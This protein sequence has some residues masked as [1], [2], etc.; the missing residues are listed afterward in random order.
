MLPAPT[1]LLVGVYDHPKITSDE[2][3]WGGR[4]TG[5]MAHVITF[6]RHPG[7]QEWTL[8]NF[9]FSHLAGVFFKTFKLVTYII[10][11]KQEANTFSLFTI[12]LIV[13]RCLVLISV[14]AVNGKLRYVDFNCKILSKLQYQ[15][16]PGFPRTS[17][18]HRLLKQQTRSYSKGYLHVHIHLQ[19]AGLVHRFAL[20]LTSG[21]R[22]CWMLL[23][24]FPDTFTGSH[25]LS[26]RLNAR[27]LLIGFCSSNH[28]SMNWGTNSGK[29]TALDGCHD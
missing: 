16:S 21:P 8:Q 14:A 2:K 23:T 12:G 19:T 7:W 1:I 26:S 24:T 3:V 28:K 9:L 20:A 11:R 27:K 6:G 25:I 22:S 10:I 5:H 13:W 17:K 15:V 4:D 29:S 18:V